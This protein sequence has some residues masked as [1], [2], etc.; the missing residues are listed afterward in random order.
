MNHRNSPEI[1]WERTFSEEINLNRESRPPR[2]L[3]IR[4][5]DTETSDGYVHI[6]G[7]SSPD[8]RLLRSP[9]LI[10]DGNTYEA[11]SYLLRYGRCYLNFFFNAPFDFSAIMKG[12][13]IYWSHKPAPVVGGGFASLTEYYWK[14]SRF[15]VKDI[16]VDYNKKTGAFKIHKPKERK[17]A[18]FYDVGKFYPPKSLHDLS[19]EFLGFGK[20]KLK[21]VDFESAPIDETI[22]RCLLD[23]RL[24]RL[25]AEK[26]YAVVEKHFYV[27]RYWYSTGSLAYQYFLNTVPVQ[28]LKPFLGEDTEFKRGLISYATFCY[29]G[30]ENHLFMKGLC[31]DTSEIDINSAYPYQMSRLVS[32][33]RGHWERT[34][35]G[36][37]NDADYGFYLVRQMYDGATPF[38]VTTNDPTDPLHSRTIRKNYYPLTTKTLVPDFRT[39]PEVDFIRRHG[40]RVDVVDGYEFFSDSREPFYPFKSAVK[41]LFALK[42]SAERKSLE[43]RLAKGLGVTGYGKLGEFRYHVGKLFNPVYAAYITGLTRVYINEL[44]AEHFKAV[45]EVYTDCVIGEL[46][47]DDIEE[48]PGLGGFKLENDKVRKESV[49]VQTGLTAAKDGTLIRKRGAWNRVH[50][51]AGDPKD[52][53][54]KLD[55]TWHDRFLSIRNTKGHMVKMGE[56]IQRHRLPDL[57]TFDDNDVRR[58]DYWDDNRVWL[59]SPITREVLFTETVRSRP[60]SDDWVLKVRSEQEE[61]IA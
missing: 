43:Y 42:A 60:L 54:V 15:Q 6:I 45:Y 58:F 4:A 13:L 28:E 24:T 3:G 21:E 12:A 5:Y 55:S 30:A 23:A 11:L 57:C 32:L 51:Y 40:F 38:Q 33:T 37:S 50:E 27:P 47:K 9:Y 26:A 16:V 29:R 56:A 53:D 52:R 7:M 48:K 59:T 39:K 17:T 34:E 10:T 44:A 14:E 46:R 61:I 25:L 35:G 19:I 41:R 2:Y 18:S 20:G 49:F 22:Q 31:E 1:L 8:D 36:M